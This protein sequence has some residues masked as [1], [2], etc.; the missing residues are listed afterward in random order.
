MH[1]G[2]IIKLMII[3]YFN[4]LWDI[5]GISAGSAIKAIEFIRAINNLGH[6][7]HLEWRSSQPNG[8]VTTTEKVKES[9]K[10]ALQKYLHEPKKLALNIPHAIEEYRILKQQKPDIFFNRIELYTYSGALLSKLLNL[11]MV[12]EADCPPT[13]EFMNFYGK[14]YMHLGNLAQ[15]IEMSV[16]QQADAVI[17][18]SK[19][20]KDYYVDNGIAAEKIHII[21]NGADPEKFRPRPKPEALARQYDLGDKVVIGWVGS[22]AGWNGIEN[23]VDMALHVLENYPNAAFMMVGGGA[24]KQFF[25]EKLHVRDFASRVILPGTV[26]HDDVPDYLACMDIVLAPYPK[27]PFWYPSSMKVFEYMAAG[28]TVLASNVGQIGEIIRDGD[29]GLLFDPDVPEELTAKTLQALQD[30]ELRRKTGEQARRDVLAKYTWEQHARTMIAIFEE[31]LARR[32]NG[33]A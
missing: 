22:L 10:P 21:P 29:N 32:R 12:V 18:I 23:L 24:N 28:K 15:R 17:A 27:L 5:K 16:L 11:P 31:V 1:G 14:H 13:Y 6:T 20:L 33:K 4:Y 7:A 30:A 8:T 3:S 9:L 2:K 19:I 26:P 25:T